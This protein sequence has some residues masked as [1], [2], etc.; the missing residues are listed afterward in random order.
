MLCVNASRQRIVST[1]FSCM[2]TK[3]LYQFYC[4][5]QS[6]RFR[7]DCVHRV[8]MLVTLY[9]RWIHD[10]VTAAVNHISW[11]DVIDSF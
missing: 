11:S 1:L 6:L 4:M 8:N 7:T 5:S 9:S 10:L 3:F 2:N